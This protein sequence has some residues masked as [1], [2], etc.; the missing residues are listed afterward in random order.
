MTQ[1]LLST[2]GDELLDHPDADPDAVAV[3]LRHIAVANRWFGGWWAVRRGLER[4][5]RQLGDSAIERPSGVPWRDPGSREPLGTARLTLLDIGCGAGDLAAKTV[6][7]GARRG[8]E[9]VPLGLERHRT[10]AALARRQRIPTLLGCAGQLPIRDKSVDIVLASQLI[11]HLTPEAIVAFCQAADRL[12]RLGVVIADLRRSAWAMAG[13]WLGS[14]ALRFDAATRAD[15]LTSVR[16]G[17]HSGELRKLLTRAGVPAQVERSAG[18]RLVATWQ[19]EQ[20]P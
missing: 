19:P 2:V 16:R 18:F 15:G 11:H 20:R 13:F 8:L 7:W 17:F 10:A 12:A 9:I 14:R 3:S 1:A 4:V 5:T 6:A